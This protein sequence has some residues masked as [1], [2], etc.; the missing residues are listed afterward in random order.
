MFRLL[1]FKPYIRCL[2]RQKNQTN[3]KSN[4]NKLER[5]KERKLRRLLSASGLLLSIVSCT[6]LIHVEVRIQDHHRLILHWVATHCDHL[7]K[8][9]LRNVRQDYER[10]QVK[11]GSYSGDDWKQIRSEWELAQSGGAPVCWTGGRGC[12]NPSRANT[13][14]L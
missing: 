4:S 5:K 1:T 9:I 7:E 10:W 11:K 3:R 6:A 8:E 2:S 13:Q 14:G 12:R